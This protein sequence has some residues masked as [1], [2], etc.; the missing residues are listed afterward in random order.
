MD[1]LVNAVERIPD[2]FPLASLLKNITRA[3]ANETQGDIRVQ[4]CYM[5]VLW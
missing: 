2:D 4:M 1:L 3:L 5:S